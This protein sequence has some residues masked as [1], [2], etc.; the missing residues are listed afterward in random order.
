MI[1]RN[2]KSILRTPIK[3]ILFALLI[4]A[5]TAFLYL[6]VN[7]WAA[8]SAMLREWDEN[9]TTIV[10]MEYLEDY[11]SNKGSKSQ[12]MLEDVANIDFDAIASNENV[13][14]WQPRM[15]KRVWPPDLLPILRMPS[16]VIPVC[17][18]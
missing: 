8:S 11:G 6:S 4:A 2:I 16:T 10:T 18:L 14:L 9:C 15:Q 7:T 3:T 13:L 17:S 5:V 1:S 12:A